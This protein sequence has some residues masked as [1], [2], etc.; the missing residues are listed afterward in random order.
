MM[1]STTPCELL[2]AAANRLI[3]DDP[4]RATFRLQGRPGSP[5]KIVLACVQK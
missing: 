3:F 1:T 4:E 5:V 2:G